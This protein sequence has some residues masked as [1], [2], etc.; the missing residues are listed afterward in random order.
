MF[1]YRFEVSRQFSTKLIKLASNVGT[2]LAD[3]N[4]PERNERVEN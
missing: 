4:P 1:V 3:I 2:P